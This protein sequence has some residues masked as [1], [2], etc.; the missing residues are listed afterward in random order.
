MD[1]NRRWKGIFEDLNMKVLF[2]PASQST[3]LVFGWPDPPLADTSGWPVKSELGWNFTAVDRMTCRK[4]T[5]IN[6]EQKIH[7]CQSML[8]PALL[9]EELSFDKLIS[10]R[11]RSKIPIISAML[12]FHST[13]LILLWVNLKVKQGQGIPMKPAKIR[14][15]SVVPL[16]RL[17]VQLLKSK[18]LDHCWNQNNHIAPGPRLMGHEPD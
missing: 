7:N 18:N 3:P 14:F 11:N 15:H 5:R 2:L 4:W 6:Q 8:S 9:F 1:L 12:R 17:V 16:G 10:A 13:L